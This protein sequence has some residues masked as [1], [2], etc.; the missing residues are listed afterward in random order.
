MG[1]KCLINDPDL[2]TQQTHTQLAKQK[3]A[4]PKAKQIFKGQSLC[5]LSHTDKELLLKT[6]ERHKNTTVLGGIFCISWPFLYFYQNPLKSQSFVR[7]ISKHSLIQSSLFGSSSNFSTSKYSCTPGYPRFPWLIIPLRQACTHSISCSGS[8]L[9]HPFA[10]CSS[11]QLQ[12]LFQIHWGTCVKS[13]EISETENTT[14]CK[15]FFFFPSV[16]RLCKPHFPEFIRQQAEQTAEHP[17]EMA[18]TQSERMWHLLWIK[19]TELTHSGLH[20][21]EALLAACQALKQWWHPVTSP[22]SKRGHT[23]KKTSLSRCTAMLWMIEAGKMAPRKGE[24]L[25]MH[26]H[27]PL[28]THHKEQFLPFTRNPNSFHGSPRK[29]K[30]HYHFSNMQ[31]TC[32]DRIYAT[33]NCRTAPSSSSAHWN[34]PLHP[35]FHWPHTSGTISAL[36]GCTELLHRLTQLQSSVIQF[37][38]LKASHPHMFLIYQETGVRMK[39]ASTREMG[40]QQLPLWLSPQVT[41]LGQLPRTTSAKSNTW[42]AQ[43]QSLAVTNQQM[44]RQKRKFMNKK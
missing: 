41:S 35:F 27:Q 18:G 40:R 29:G 31:Q 39:P 2:G 23:D 37:V 15:I 10:S 25:W 33:E 7:H 1:E 14:T 38:L 19:Q 26:S 28:K 6:Q 43:P 16:S 3:D 34:L 13:C 44:L 30:L 8:Q 4:S 5:P 36:S 32:M 24:Y 11:T 22:Q 20:L 42:C 9:N 21:R 12:E 17:C